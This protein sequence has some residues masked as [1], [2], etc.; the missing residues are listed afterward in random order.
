MHGH[1]AHAL[2]AFLD[3]RRIRL[4]TALRIG[5]EPLDER[6]ERRRAD[7]F[8]SPREIDDAEQV[9]ERLLACRPDRDARVR[10]RLAE[11]RGERVCDAAPVAAA[12]QRSEDL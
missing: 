3:D 6:A 9:R 12:M 7:R 2:G 4:A 1:D 11:E 10:S 8:E 5:I